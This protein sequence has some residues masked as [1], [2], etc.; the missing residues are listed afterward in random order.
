M[1]QM[2]RTYFDI[3][4]SDF[5]PMLVAGE[6]RCLIAVKFQ[7]DEQRLPDALADLQR[8]LHGKF[9]FVRDRAKVAGLTKQLSD[10]LVGHS[11]EFRRRSRAVVGHAVQARRAARLRRRA[12]RGGR[13]VRRIGASRRQPER[14]ARRRQHDA[15]QPD[16]DRHPLPPGRRQQRQPHGIRRWT[17]H[18][19]AT[20]ADGGR[21]NRLTAPTALRRQHRQ[22]SPQAPGACR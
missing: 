6:G 1:T 22:K 12:T 13:H 20:A 4:K 7:V 19:G 5:G 2:T 21:A 16:T 8:E 14:C 18:E 10:Y 9:E 3:M 15:H 17:G 11:Q